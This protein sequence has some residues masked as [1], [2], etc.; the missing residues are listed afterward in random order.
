VMIGLG[1]E[2]HVATATNTLALTFMSVGGSIHGKGR[3][4]P[5]PSAHVYS[6]HGHWFWTGRATLAN[7]LWCMC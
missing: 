5:Q 3:S 1:V 7:S 6:S 2:A 4:Q